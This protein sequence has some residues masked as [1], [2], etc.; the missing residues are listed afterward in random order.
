MFDHVITNNSKWYMSVG[1]FGFGP[2]KVKDP[3]GHVAYA[4]S[5][6]KAV[7]QAYLQEL[8]SRKLSDVEFEAVKKNMIGD[9]CCALI[10]N[11][12]VRDLC[13]EHSLSCVY[14]IMFGNYPVVTSVDNYITANRRFGKAASSK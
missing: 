14:N 2:I 10:E 5:A 11:E 12:E 7:I 13:N 3:Q 6:E 8:T 4:S 1:L 9:F